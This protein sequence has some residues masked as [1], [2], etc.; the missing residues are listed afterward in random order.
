MKYLIITLTFVFAALTIQ[1]QEYIEYKTKDKIKIEY[2]WRKESKLKNNSPYV[3]Y[4]RITNN[5]V[6]KKLVGF[7]LFYFWNESTH[8][9]SG[10]KEYCIKPGKS[11]EGKRWN[12]VIKSDIKTLEEIHSSNFSWEIENLNIEKNE[13]CKSGLRLRLEPAHDMYLTK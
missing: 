6:E 13:L 2:K 10:Y 5:S 7:E 11:I 4:L 3:L 12:L 8:S 9:R 1:G